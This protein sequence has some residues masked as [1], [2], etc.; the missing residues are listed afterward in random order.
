MTVYLTSSLGLTDPTIYTQHVQILAG[1][2]RMQIR[3]CE[4][5]HPACNPLA[6][7]GRALHCFHT[8]G[9]DYQ[10]NPLKV[11]I[12]DLKI[13]FKGTPTPDYKAYKEVLIDSI[14]LHIFSYGRRDLL[15][16]TDDSTIEG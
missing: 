12:G 11:T 16:C 10:Y 7:L 9:H 14:I 13:V 1:E 4:L 8:L 3:G 2:I 5:G 15:A 6:V